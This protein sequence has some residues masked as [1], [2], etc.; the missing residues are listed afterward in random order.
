MG[1]RSPKLFDC[2]VELFE[3]QADFNDYIIYSLVLVL[4]QRALIVNEVINKT[5]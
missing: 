2:E 3:E 1:G 4:P 5:G